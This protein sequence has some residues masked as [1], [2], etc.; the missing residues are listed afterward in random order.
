MCSLF[1]AFFFF[2]FFKPRDVPEA[3]ERGAGFISVCTLFSFSEI[4][5]VKNPYVQGFSEITPSHLCFFFNSCHCV[6]LTRAYCWCEGSVEREGK[7][8][9]RTNPVWGDGFGLSLAVRVL[10]FS[11]WCFVES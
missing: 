9:N 4:Y 11:V 6:F 1:L 2:F 8:K 7:R 3:T 5:Y 10:S